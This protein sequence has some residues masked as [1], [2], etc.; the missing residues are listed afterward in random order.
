MKKIVLSALLLVLGATASVQGQ[1]TYATPQYGKIYNCT[2]DASYS[3]PAASPGAVWWQQRAGTTSTMLYTYE[4]FQLDGGG[5]EN[6][7]LTWAKPV[8]DLQTGST[9]WEAT[10]VGGPQCTRTAVTPNGF[11]INFRGCSDG[12]TRVCYT[13]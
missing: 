4:Y 3:G 9:I 10:F 2:Y 1:T 5:W 6:Y 12:H 11:T 7:K 8:K 13:E